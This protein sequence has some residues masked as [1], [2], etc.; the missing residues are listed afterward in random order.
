M[1]EASRSKPKQS[2]QPMK[3]SGRNSPEKQSRS[4]KIEDTTK[5]KQAEDASLIDEIP[6]KTLIDLA[7]VSISISRNGIGIYANLKF[8]NLFGLQS[9]A[10]YIG[11]QTYEFFAPQRQVEI[12][13]FIRLRALGLP[14]PKEYEMIALRADGSQFPMQIVVDRVN[15]VGGPANIAFTTDISERK[16]AEQALHE[17][18][19]RYRSIF[20]G[21]QDAVF[22]ESLDGRIL[23][24]NPSA[25]EMFGYTRQQFLAMSVKG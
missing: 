20:E 3:F 21:V 15:L 22:V 16:Q 23:D 4:T 13:E 17:S 24:A 6:F 25:C 11:R 10:E 2:G 19:Q 14:V 12:K 7:P 1:E 8:L 18:E 5:L 9:L